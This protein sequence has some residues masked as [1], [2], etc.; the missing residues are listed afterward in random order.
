MLERWREGI[1]IEKREGEKDQRKEEGQNG[2]L[3]RKSTRQV[4]NRGDAPPRSGR[5]NAGHLLIPAA[6]RLHLALSPILTAGSAFNRIPGF[7]F[8]LA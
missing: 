8:A 3:S 4:E 2:A 7:S 1:G 5:Q 6:L